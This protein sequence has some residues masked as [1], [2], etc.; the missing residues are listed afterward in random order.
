MKN[1]VSMDD[2]RG[3]KGCQRLRI[4]R[5]T[6]RPRDLEF[7]LVERLNQG[8]GPT[9]HVALAVDPGKVV[10]QLELCYIFCV[11]EGLMVTE[12]ERGG[13]GRSRDAW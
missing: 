11:L 8:H 3:W 5:H 4:R 7:E 13:F 2:W 9:V 1:L 6:G 12:C 10:N